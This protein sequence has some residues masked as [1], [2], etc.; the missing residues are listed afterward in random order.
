MEM[1]S[2][3][4]KI[5]SCLM[6]ASACLAGAQNK[7]APQAVPAPNRPVPGLPGNPNVPPGQG[8]SDITNLKKGIIIGGAV[9]GAGGLFVPWGTTADLSGVDPL[10]GTYVAGGPATVALPG[11]CAFNVTYDESNIGSGATSPLYTNKLKLI[12][13]ADVAVNSSRHLNAGE[14]KTV[15]TQPYLKEGSNALM[16][17]LDDGN[18]VAESNEGN[19]FFSIKYTLKCKA[20]PGNPNNPNGNPTG[21][22]NPNK[23]PDVTSAKG[24]IIIG[25][26]VGGAGG[27]FVPWGGVADLSS[28]DPLPGTVVGDRC[29]FN[30]TYYET[31]IG[32]ADTSPLY[33]NK[34]KLDGATD[35]SINS[36]R[37]LN[38]GEVKPV[39]T[40]AYLTMGGHGLELSLDDLHQVTESN[41]GNNQF[42]IRYTLQ[43]HK[44][45]TVANCD[46]LPDLVPILPNPMNGTVMVKNVGKCPAAASKLTLDCHKA[47]VVGGGG[48]CPEVP[49]TVSAPYHDPM[50]PDDVTVN[51]PALAPGASFSHTLTFWAALKWTTGTYTFVGKA[52]AANTVA[53]SNEGNNVVNSVLVVP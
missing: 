15:T 32:S 31:N 18:A 24:G 20:T 12:G 4:A 47:G 10:P 2:A 49:A 3:F 7:P 23:L 52:D 45:T 35:V 9:G 43:C 11:R 19:N 37:H 13:P 44:P 5:V 26:A 41:E 34:L 53:E 25:G 17:Y 38:A 16:L 1:K 50:F 6:V 22:P 39:D 14:T 30:V 40:Q 36:A 51:V 33:T 48:G 29:A 8:K 46:G 21:G 27:K 42:S 28:L